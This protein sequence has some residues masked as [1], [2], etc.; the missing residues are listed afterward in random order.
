M[1]YE[2]IIVKIEPEFQDEAAVTEIRDWIMAEFTSVKS[3]TIGYDN[4]FGNIVQYP[5]STKE[6]L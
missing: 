1:K 5:D 3:T 4:G 6:N 2:Y